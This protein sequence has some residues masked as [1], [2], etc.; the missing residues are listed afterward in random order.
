MIERIR[1]M[2]ERIGSDA[3]VR[4]AMASRD[5]DI[6]KL[7]ETSCPTL[8]VAA[9]EDQIR[10]LDEAADRR[11]RNWSSAAARWLSQLRSVR[12]QTPSLKNL[13]IM[14]ASPAALPSGSFQGRH[15]SSRRQ[16][17]HV[18]AT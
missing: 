12:P 8:I 5:D 11:E 3:F 10:T 4:Q 15:R 16:L 14:T 13:K 1:A 7:R 6:D 17:S 18:E 2:G 9:A